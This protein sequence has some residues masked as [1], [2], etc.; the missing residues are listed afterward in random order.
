MCILLKGAPI[1]GVL[2]SIEVTSTYFAVRNYWRG[3]FASV[4]AATMF[5][6]LAVIFTSEKTITALF[7]T[8]FDSYPFDIL[9]MLVFVR[10]CFLLP[11]PLYSYSISS[12]SYSCSF[13]SILIWV[14]FF[15]GVRAKDIGMTKTIYL[16]I[17]STSHYLSF[18]I[19]L[20]L[21]AGADADVIQ[22]VKCHIISTY[23]LFKYILNQSKH[24]HTQKEYDWRY[25][26]C[27]GRV[28]RL[29]P[30]THH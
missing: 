4:V 28:L 10:S 11:T 7:T 16:S 27:Y 22:L 26:R 25:L 1:G 8:E 3:F 24:T 2:F 14:V 29:R 12:Y 13:Y 23:A 17:L 19:D 15:W 5:R 9:E 18:P 20:L 30:Q 21:G 6:L